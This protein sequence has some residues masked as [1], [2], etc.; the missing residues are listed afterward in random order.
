MGINETTEAAAEAETAE[1]VECESCGKY[2]PA[3][4]VTDG[5]DTYTAGYAPSAYPSACTDCRMR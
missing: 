3:D 1:L 5:D 4:E 2:K